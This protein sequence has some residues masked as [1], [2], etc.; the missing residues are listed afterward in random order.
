MGGGGPKA[1]CWGC[2]LAA[3][4]CKQARQLAVPRARCMLPQAGI[5]QASSLGC[6]AVHSQQRAHLD[7]K[8]HAPKRA[9]AAGRLRLQLGAALL[10]L[11]QG[12]AL[13]EDYGRGRAAAAGSAPALP[14]LRGKAPSALGRPLQRGPGLAWLVAAL[15]P[16][17][18]P[19]PLLPALA[20][21]APLASCREPAGPNR[22]CLDQRVQPPGT[23]RLSSG[24]RRPHPPW[25]TPAAGTAAPLWRTAWRRRHTPCAGWP[26]PC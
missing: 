19:L 15:P 7:S 17:P 12:S 10:E 23:A 2:C 18:A 14:A 6:M 16:P 4:A 3:A 20:L 25:Q 24:A 5:K 13:D 11:L 8:G 21:P 9:P 1:G 26:G 22:G